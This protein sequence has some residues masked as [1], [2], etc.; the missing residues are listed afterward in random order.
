MGDALLGKPGHLLT[1]GAE[2]PQLPQRARRTQLEIV[3]GCATHHPH[4]QG[5]EE[6]GIVIR[7]VV[8]VGDG[9]LRVISV[10]QREAEEIDR[11]LNGLWTSTATLFLLG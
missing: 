1:A 8:R 2:Q 3:L 5:R 9:Y 10:L 4:G 7:A 6:F 11:N